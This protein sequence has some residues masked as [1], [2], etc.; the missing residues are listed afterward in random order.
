MNL[1]EKIKDMD[2]DEMAECIAMI[3]YGSIYALRGIAH[4]A[5]TENIMSDP[6]YEKAL[7]RAKEMLLEEQNG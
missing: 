2:I 3:V 6:N 7:S 1:C 4:L 5:T